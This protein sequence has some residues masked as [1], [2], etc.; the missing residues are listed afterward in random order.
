MG[1]RWRRQHK[2][3]PDTGQ[4]QALEE[5]EQELE[6]ARTQHRVQARKRDQEQEGVIRRMER[7]A[8]ENHLGALVWDVLTG[9]NHR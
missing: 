8:E 6:R 3:P 5:A 2:A 1:P 7:L 4:A 9:G